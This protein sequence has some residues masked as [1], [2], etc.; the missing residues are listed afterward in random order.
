MVDGQCLK[1]LSEQY[2]TGRSQDSQCYGL[3]EVLRLGKVPTEECLLDGIGT[4]LSSDGFLWNGYLI[5]ILS[6]LC[7]GPHALETHDVAHLRDK[8]HASQTAHQT[9]GL[10]GVAAQGEEVI[11]GTDWR[12]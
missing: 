5:L 2:G 9:D 11:E 6:S 8:P 4:D 3:V 7:N 10:D 12:C 1:G